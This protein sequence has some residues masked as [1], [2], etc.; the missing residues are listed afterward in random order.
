M[1]R[2]VACAIALL[3][4]VVSCQ[5]FDEEYADVNCQ[6]EWGG[7]IC[8][9]GNL[10]Y[11]NIQICDFSF[12]FYIFRLFLAHAIANSAWKHAKHSREEL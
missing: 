8:D 4:A 1:M 2:T 5:V 9:C 10:K 7:T 6:Y 11:V 12:F 3:L